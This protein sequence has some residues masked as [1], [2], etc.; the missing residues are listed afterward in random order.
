MTYTSLS[1]NI[2]INRLFFFRFA[3]KKNIHN[4]RA[5]RNIR[6]VRSNLEELVEHFINQQVFVVAVAVLFIVCRCVF[7]VVSHFSSSSMFNVKAL[8]HAVF[9]AVE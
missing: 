1:D 6:A 9:A 2:E 3:Q 8:S 7:R 4:K 5:L